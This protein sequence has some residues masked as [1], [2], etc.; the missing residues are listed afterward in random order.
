MDINFYD[1]QIWVAIS[2]FFFFIIFGK[3]VWK[4]L[5]S[6]LDNKILEIKNE[7]D[8]AQKLHKDAKE[9]YATESK[10]IQDLDL[11]VKEIIDKSK[12]QSY[13]LLLENKKKIEHQID[14]LEKEALEKIKVIQN[15]A[16]EEIKSDIISKSSIIAEKLLASKV[17]SENQLKIMQESVNQTKNIIN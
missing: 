15:Q 12:N 13:E 4:Q 6:Y 11:V 3:M 10:K 8:E 7:I 16:M 2:F 17:S 14:K 9:L 1:P 5:R